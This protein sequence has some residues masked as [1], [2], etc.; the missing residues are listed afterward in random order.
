VFETSNTKLPLS[1]TEPMPFQDVQAIENVVRSQDLQRFV[2]PAQG[3]LSNALLP[4]DIKD[5]QG[6]IEKALAPEIQRHVVE[7]NSRREGLVI[8]LRE[9]GFFESGSATLRSSSQDAIDRLAVILQDRDELLRIEGHTDNVP[10]HTAQFHSNWELSTARATELIEMFITRYHF[11][12]ARLAAAGYAEYHPVDS[13]GTAEGK[14]HNRRVDIVVL[15]P[16]TVP[17]AVIGGPKK[18]GTPDAAAPVKAELAATASAVPSAAG[19]SDAA[20]AD[21]TKPMAPLKRNPAAAA[22][23]KKAAPLP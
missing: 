11:A 21:R 4:G 16:S 1:T 8:S 19:K 17:V 3:A 15:K 12:P 9:I 22:P 14:A 13:N 6:E 10:I 7:L 2:Q 5:I 23:E 18:P 20:A